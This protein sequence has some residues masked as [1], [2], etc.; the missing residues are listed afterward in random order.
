MPLIAAASYLAGALS[1]LIL[2]LLLVLRWQGRLHGRALTL[3]CVTSA[4][5]CGGQALQVTSAVALPALLLY[6]L[7][8]A[9][10]AAWLNLLLHLL[11]GAEGAR[12]PG[13]VRVIVH[14]AW[15]A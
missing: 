6:V 10:G 5:W 7:E 9:R 11:G 2:S 13:R 14:S 12:L 4:I 15:L 3:A 8:I 1:F